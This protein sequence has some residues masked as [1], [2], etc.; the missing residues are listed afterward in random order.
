M[1]TSSGIAVH[2][3]HA[4]ERVRVRVRGQLVAGRAR[5]RRRA[6]ASRPPP[7]GPARCR[8]APAAGPPAA[9]AGRSAA[10]SSAVDR[11]PVVEQRDLPVRG[12]HAAQPAA[13]PA[14]R[15][16]QFR[17]GCLAGCTGAGRRRRSGRPAPGSGRRAPARS[18]RRPAAPAPPAGW[19]AGPAPGRAAAS[20]PKNTASP[21]SALRFLIRW[22][23]PTSVS[24]CRRRNPA[25]AARLGEERW[26]RWG[27]RPRGHGADRSRTRRAARPGRAA[28]RRRGP[29]RTCA[30]QDRHIAGEQA[31]ASARSGSAASPQAQ[32]Q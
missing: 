5:R 14:D 29:P 20:S 10:T 26:P 32:S 19:S 8:A 31:R 25:C 16:D 2:V 22:L 30:C 12:Q 4:A 9:A 3:H 18:G 13:H 17:A 24:R 28:R 23:P 11:V 6:G 15:V 27:C 7:P 21:A 1:S